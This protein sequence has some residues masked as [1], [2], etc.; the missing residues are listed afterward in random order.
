MQ[1][2]I[3]KTGAAL[4][5]KRHVGNAVVVDECPGDHKAVEYLVAVELKW[6]ISDNSERRPELYPD[7]HFAREESLRDPEGVEE[8]AG[9]VEGAHEEQ[10]AQTRL[11]HRLLHAFSLVC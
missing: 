9:D 3:L 4:P 2:T 6:S 11:A 10:P 1:T 5:V 7:V 8:R